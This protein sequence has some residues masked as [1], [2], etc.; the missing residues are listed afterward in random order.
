VNFNEQVHFVQDGLAKQV[1]VLNDAALGLRN[2]QEQL[3][4]AL[5]TRRSQLSD[6]ISQSRE[7]ADAVD[8][9]AREA[10]QQIERLSQISKERAEELNEA[11]RSHRSALASAAIESLGAITDASGRHKDLLLQQT[12]HLVDAMNMA[13]EQAQN[14]AQAQITAANSHLAQMSEA[15]FGASQQAEAMFAARLEDA[16]NLIEQSVRLTEEAGARSAEQLSRNLGSTRDAVNQF[17]DLL[18]DFEHRIGTLP[19]EAARQAQAASERLAEGIASG[20][21]HMAIGGSQIGRPNKNAVHACGTCDCVYR[22]DALG[23]FNLHRDGDVAIDLL[24]VVGYRAVAVA[25]LGY[26]HTSNS[27][28]RI[29]R[30]GYRRGGIVGTV[31]HGNQEVVKA[32]V[33]QTLDFHRVIA[34]RAHDGRTAAVLERH[35]LWNKANDVVGRVFA[36]QQDPVKAS[37]AEHF[38]ADG[39]G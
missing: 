8:Q 18:A 1:S 10:G 17:A 25:A 21:A 39:V 3:D 2:D 31:Y 5:V 33:E 32:S 12:Q 28:G 37:H 4:A 35:E 34:G 7:A 22:S 36:V 23:T 29:A 19:N 15:A 6:L 14:S 24:K 30:G 20:I 26:R 13:A 9:T 38:G 16:R 11:A 27:L